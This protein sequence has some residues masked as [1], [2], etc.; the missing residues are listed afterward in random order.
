MNR[1]AATGHLA[2][3]LEGITRQWERPRQSA[4]TRFTIALAREAGADAAAVAH[5]LAKRLSWTV[6]DRELLEV[7]A[8][9][10]GLQTSLLESVDEKQVGWFLDSFQAFL[11]VPRIDESAFIQHLI[12]T[13]AML[14]SR[15]ECIIVGRGAAQLLPTDT[16]LRVRLVAPFADRI[17]AFSKRFQI[18]REEAE[19]RIK[20]LEQERAEFVR[21]H[22]LKDP[23]D[24][25][26]Y[27]LVLNVSRLTPAKCA[28]VI[29]GAL[30]VVSGE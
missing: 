4:K 22:F 18:D 16:T 23:T 13:L 3:N 19:R 2:Q 12:K 21:R 14:A 7:I 10:L 27:D 6:Y 30:R 8:Q 24:P 11:A 17:V 9:D 26:N 15:G 29:C 1:A 5:E 28:E 25:A 20:R